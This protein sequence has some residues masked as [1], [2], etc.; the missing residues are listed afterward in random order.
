MIENA[1]RKRDGRLKLSPRY[2]EKDWNDAFNGRD[3]WDTAINIVEDRIK[4]RW[5]DHAD[6]LLDEG[7]G[8]STACHSSSRTS[9]EGTASEVFCTTALALPR[10]TIPRRGAQTLCCLTQSHNTN[11]RRSR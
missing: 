9:L 1:K 10:T 8:L 6:R 4:G 3:A 11:L 7:L 2:N 5:L